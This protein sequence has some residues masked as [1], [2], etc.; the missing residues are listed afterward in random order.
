MKPAQVNYLL[1]TTTFCL[2][3]L[4]W[5]TI[6]VMRVVGDANYH[7]PTAQQQRVQNFK[8]CTDNEYGNADKPCAELLK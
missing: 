4:T 8:D 3:F 1:L 5:G 7:A 6:I 2:A